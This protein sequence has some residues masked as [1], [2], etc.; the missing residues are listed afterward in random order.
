MNF[1][2]IKSLNE[3]LKKNSNLNTILKNQD[4]LQLLCL[5]NTNLFIFAVP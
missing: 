2:I 4:V 3:K 1:F 5:I